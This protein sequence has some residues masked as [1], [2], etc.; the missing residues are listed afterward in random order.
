M[1][2]NLIMRRGVH[3]DA[4][5]NTSELPTIRLESFAKVQIPMSM[6]IG[7]PCTPC[8]SVG[9]QVSVGQKIGDSPAFMSAPIHASISG[10]V[11]AVKKV[12][13]SSGSSVEVVEIESDGLNTIHDSV[14][15]PV[16]ESRADFIKAIRESGLVGLGG[17]SFPTHVKMSPPPG[18]EPDILVI[19]AA[20]CEP[21]ITA[22]YRHILEHA[23]EIIEGIISTMNWLGIPK[24]VIGIEDNKKDAAG[25]LRFQIGKSGASDSIRVKLLKTIYPQ[26]AEKPLIFNTTGRKVPTGG[27]PHDVHVMVLNVATVRYVA[28][29]LKTGMPLVRKHLTIDG[30]AVA[31][32]CNVTAPIGSFIMD[33][34]DQI[35][36]VKQSP[37]KV[38][39]GGPMMGVAMDRDNVGILK[40]NNAILLFDAN[41]A[42]IPEESPCIRC[43]KCIDVCPMNLM[44]T[45]IDAA[46]RAKDLEDLVRFN[47]MDCI[48]CGC[49]SYICP[50]KRYLVQGIRMGKQLLRDSEAKK[51]AAVKGEQ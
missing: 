18:K 34:V 49:C 32:P 46:A 23:D 27:L 28:R 6:H 24:T 39:M 44:P 20:E 10:K 38:I 21:F 11:T 12:V 37:A 19:N 15:P 29:Y 17:A 3:P 33:I 40:A 22:D 45:G 7:A 1:I 31:R 2:H 30:S 5:K 36:G 42:A 35:G 16:I 41:D 13:S 50:A 8:V 14:K 9:D 48:E 4:S 43:S 26:G 51:K 25:L 47:T